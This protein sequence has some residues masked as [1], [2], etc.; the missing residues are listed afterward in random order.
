M[1]ASDRTSAAILSNRL[2]ECRLAHKL[3]IRILRS[4][5]RVCHGD[6]FDMGNDTLQNAAEISQIEVFQEHLSPTHIQVDVKPLWTS[7]LGSNR[8]RAMRFH[9]DFLLRGRIAFANQR[10]PT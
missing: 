5:R 6:D 8:S 7:S 4:L 3:R 10:A 2:F 9:R 1:T